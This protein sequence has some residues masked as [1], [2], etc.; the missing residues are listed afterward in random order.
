VGKGGGVREERG[1]LGLAG[2]AQGGTHKSLK[3]ASILAASVSAATAAL[4]LVPVRVS[5]LA[6]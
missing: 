6:M 2:R 4:A 3:N 5:R 1:G